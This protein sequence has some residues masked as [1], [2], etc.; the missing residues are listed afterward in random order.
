MKK[1]LS[2]MFTAVLLIGVLAGC[3]TGNTGSKSSS[4][5]TKNGVTTITFWAAPNPTQ[6]VFWKDMANKF[7]KSHKNIKVNVSQMKETPSSEASIQS[8]IAGGSAPTI[9]ENISR[10]FAAELAKSKAIVPLDQMSGFNK[11]IQSRHMDKTIK[12]WSFSDGHQYV[13]PIYSNAMLFGWR[14]DIL[15]KLGVNQA[16]TTYSQVYSL[17]KK[18]K[19]KYPEKFIWANSDLADPTAWKR[20]FDFF[21]LYDAA[22]GGNSFIKG[23]KFV[24]KDQAGIQTLTFLQKLQQENALMT[25]QVKNP[26][27]TGVEVFSSVGPW[28]FTTWQ[29]QFP[30]MQYKKT[31]V[32]S[33]PPVPDNM[34]GKNVYTF[35]DTKGLAIYSSA[36]KKQQKAAMTFVQWVYSNPQHDLAWLKKTDLP[37]ARDDLSTNATFKSF[38]AKNPELV[39][40]AKEIPYAIPTIDNPKYNDLQTY[41]GQDAVNPIAKGQGQPK[42]AWNK[43]KQAIEG[44]MK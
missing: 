28:T 14:I 12:G 25:K 11:V 7:M 20:W 5:T 21:M 2:L 26:F 39:P 24:A 40:Y 32:L 43:M 19:A 17:A 6:E 8:A 13:L 16:P 3:T 15:K 34:S 1:V 37:P 22:S 36:T 38:F 41:I 10:G 27:E 23:N 42:A 30:K 4:S 44:A 29:Q 31:Y 18:L 9:S 33:T 35:A